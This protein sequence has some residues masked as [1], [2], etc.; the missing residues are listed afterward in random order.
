MT[1]RRN[2]V[3][4]MA[5]TFGGAAMFREN[6]F[7]SLFKANVIAGDRSPEE[8]A[9]DESYWGEIQRAFDSGFAT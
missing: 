5:A 7:S 4:S 3:S 2:F 9:E 1:S 6:A 8:V